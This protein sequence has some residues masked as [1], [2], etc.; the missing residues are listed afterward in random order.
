MRKLLLLISFFSLTPIFLLVTSI[1]LLSLSFQQKSGGKTLSLLY[2]TPSSTIAYAALP[3]NLTMEADIQGSDARLGKVLAFLESYNSPLTPYAATIVNDADKYGI[4]YRLLP[5][6]GAQESGICTKGSSAR[7][8]NCWGW[9]VYNHK[10]TSFESYEDAIDTISRY[11]A[12]KKEN[13]IDTLDAIGDIYNPS[14]Y[15]DWKGNVNSFMSL[16]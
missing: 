15:H 12:K 8:K 9:G 16:L 1:M 14:N 5:A 11:F 7:W 3:T 4:D 10:V 6:I 13:G 2:S